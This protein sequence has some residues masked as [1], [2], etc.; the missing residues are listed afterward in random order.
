MKKNVLVTLYVEVEVDDEKYTPEF[1]EDF[2]Q[3]MYA[4]TSIDDHIKHLAQMYARNIVEN[5]SFI[6]GYGHTDEM[7]I[8]F[9]AKGG[10]EEIINF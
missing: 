5:R 7:G 6:E 4:F 10:E 8:S 2:R 9:A 3:S 1:M